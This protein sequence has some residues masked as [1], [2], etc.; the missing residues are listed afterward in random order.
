MEWECLRPHS[1]VLLF[2]ESHLLKR[3][4]NKNKLMNKQRNFPM[5]MEAK[6]APEEGQ[7]APAPEESHIKSGG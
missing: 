6:L 7:T 5:A 2:R 4:E 1:M 3:D